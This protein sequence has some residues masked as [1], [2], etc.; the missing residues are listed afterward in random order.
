MTK[1]EDYNHNTKLYTFDF[2]D[3]EKTRGGQV[4][5]ALLVKTPEGENEVKDDKGKPVIK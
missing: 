3:P 2:G 1:V 5:N 4:A